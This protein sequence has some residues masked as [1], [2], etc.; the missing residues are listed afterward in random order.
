MVAWWWG[1][2]IF[3]LGASV[4]SFLN[5]LVGRF[6]EKGK[7][8]LSGRSY[9]D[10]CRRQLRWWENIPL[11]S[12]LA[13]RGR[14][15]RC[16]SPI[17]RE[18]FLVELVM[19]LVYLL[20][21]HQFL[22][23]DFQFLNLKL[24]LELLIITFLAIVFL[25]DFHYQIIPD[26]AVFSLVILACGYHYLNSSIFQLLK[27]VLTGLVAAGFFFFLYLVTRGRGMGFGDVKLAF[28]LGFFLGPARTIL[29]LYWAF[30]TGAVVGVILVLS[31]RYRWRQPIA[32]GPFLVTGGL[33]SWWW[34]EMVINYLLG[35]YF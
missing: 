20:A 29:A 26:W 2:V 12:F 3:L 11:I 16:H 34:G 24:V 19:G 28:F 32:F 33:L 8:D 15:F 14:C 22:S 10:S 1:G 9:C 5:V 4:G 23:L 6:G 35:H 7:V 21:A 27:L 31:R 25:F 13:L 30:L 18:Y 17:P